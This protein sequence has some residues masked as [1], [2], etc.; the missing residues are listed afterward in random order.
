MRTYCPVIR[1]TSSRVGT[2]ST[3]L[4]GTCLFGG[5]GVC[6]DHVKQRPYI[7]KRR[8]RDSHT[9]GLVVEET[10]YC[11]ICQD[12]GPGRACHFNRCRTLY[13]LP[14]DVGIAVSPAERCLVF[15]A[16]VDAHEGDAADGVAAPVS[17]AGRCIGCG[18][19]FVQPDRTGR[20]QLPG[21]R[22]RSEGWAVCSTSCHG[23]SPVGWVVCWCLYPDCIATGRS[24]VSP[25]DTR[26]AFMATVESD[27]AQTPTWFRQARGER[28]S[29]ESAGGVPRQAVAGSAAGAP[30]SARIDVR[31]A[32][33]QRALR[34][35]PRRSVMVTRP[36]ATSRSFLSTSLPMS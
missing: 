33:G 27:S 25:A 29:P 14:A 4:Q 24:S 17:E 12:Q 13:E 3:P 32:A 23:V 30:A 15:V 18:R 2:A 22:R 36:R 31:R 8:E 21:L 1:P 16:A 28:P 34:A 6:E 5:R 9:T 19:R 20:R 26:N 35:S 7:H 11:G 10:P